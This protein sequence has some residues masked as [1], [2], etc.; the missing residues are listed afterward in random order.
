M[1]SRR[2]E[3]S[4]SLLTPPP[5]RHRFWSP[6]AALTACCAVSA[7]TVFALKSAGGADALARKNCDP[8]VWVIRHGE[9]SPNPQP[10]SPE[11]L[12]LNATGVARANFLSSLVANGSWPRFG[13]IYA[14]SPRAPPHVLRE[15]QT[16]LP[17]STVLNT[18]V[19]TSFAQVETAA[20]AAAARKAAHTTCAPVL[21]SWEHCRIPSLLIA[22]GCESDACT[23]CWPDGDYDTFVALDVGAEPPVAHVRAEGFR[24]HEPRGFEGYE[25]AGPERIAHSRC[26]F[27]DGTWLGDAGSR[28][29]LAANA[30]SDAA[31]NTTNATTV[32]DAACALP[33]CLAL[34]ALTLSVWAWAALFVVGGA[35]LFLEVCCCW[36]RGAL[37]CVACVRTITALRSVHAN[38]I[39]VVRLRPIP[40]GQPKERFFRIL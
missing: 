9:K 27:T 6:L 20:L 13:H 8:S 28:R 34:G 37:S 38:D 39:E 32:V 7:V 35:Y 26:R 22:L 14:S 2:E 12:G 23:R 1:E 16:V 11:V 29:A 40:P 4:A 30:T 5:P 18:P 36:H 10:G 19:D 3:L 33:P 17:L 21:I 15:L 31:A 24:R 25:C